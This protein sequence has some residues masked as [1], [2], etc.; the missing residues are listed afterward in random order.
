MG[1]SNFRN[2]FWKVL[3]VNLLFSW[4]P[5]FAQV[6]HLELGAGNHSDFVEPSSPLRF[7]YLEHIVEG[8]IEKFG[9]TAGVI[10]LNDIDG[11]AVADAREH[12]EKWLHSRGYQI[13]VIGIPGDYNTILF[14]NVKTANLGNPGG[15]QLPS[16]YNRK[17]EKG[18]KNAKIVAGLIRIASLSD[19]GLTISTQGKESIDVFQQMISEN[20]M[21]NRNWTIA[22]EGEGFEYRWPDGETYFERLRINPVFKI[23]RIYSLPHVRK[24]DTV[25]SVDG[26]S[27][28]T[29]DIESKL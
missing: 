25:L 12:M 2:P 19:T 6:L 14:P 11:K 18:T 28:G 22:V 16:D 4:Q 15:P 8:L 9:S 13:K 5:V 1:I 10:Y 23:Y 29:K 26:K 27:K 21:L 20:S 17:Y 24:C 7:R 3:I